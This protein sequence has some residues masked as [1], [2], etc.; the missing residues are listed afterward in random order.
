VLCVE[1]VGLS[2]YKDKAHYFFSD[3]VIYGNDGLYY[4]IAK[5]M[6]IKKGMVLKD[7]GLL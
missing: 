1:L 3:R 2:D 6:S 7:S 5:W 4:Y